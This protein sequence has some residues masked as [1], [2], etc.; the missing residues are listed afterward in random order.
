MKG[1]QLA[2]LRIHMVHSDHM[3]QSRPFSPPLFMT[4][5]WHA[6]TGQCGKNQRY[7]WAM[8]FGTDIRNSIQDEA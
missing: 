3:V 2:K 4:E 6:S 1:V 7:G 5:H 8:S